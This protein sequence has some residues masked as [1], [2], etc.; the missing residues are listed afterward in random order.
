MVE[1]TMMQF[2][3]TAA[4]TG[5]LVAIYIFKIKYISVYNSIYYVYMCVAIV[6]RLPL[7]LPTCLV[8]AVVPVT[9]AIA[10][11]PS[12]QPPYICSRVHTCRR[13]GLCPARSPLM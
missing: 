13:G 2:S 1:E 5:R 7:C 4:A 9:A 3:G 6:A 10:C 12:C 11:R 8:V